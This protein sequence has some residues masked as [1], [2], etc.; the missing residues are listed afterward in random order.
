MCSNHL[1]EEKARKEEL[2]R[3]LAAEKRDEQLRQ[4]K[5]ARQSYVKQYADKDMQR[6]QN[7]ILKM[8]ALETDPIEIDFIAEK[9][10]KFPT[11]ITNTK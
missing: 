7:W 4:M 10:S 3:R 8:L 6:A 2:A 9:T 1:K 5:E 11:K